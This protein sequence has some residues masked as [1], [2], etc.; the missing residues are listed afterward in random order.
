MSEHAP[1]VLKAAPVVERLRPELKAK[2][3][4]IRE[5]GV[6]PRLAIVTD[7]YRGPI[8]KYIDRKQL[9][10]REL[11][12]AV[13][14]SQARSSEALESY[15][16]QACGDPET[17]GV[18]LQLPIAG[19]DALSPT[20][21]RTREAAL[22]DSVPITR[23]VD[24]LA[25][26]SSFT[27]ATPLGVKALLDYYV[28]DFLGEEIAL[29]GNGILVN[30]PF[31][32]LAR[33]AGAKNISVIDKDTPLKDR[34]DMLHAA[35]IVIAATGNPESL[36][37]DDVGTRLPKIIVDAGT[38]ERSGKNIGDMSAELRAYAEST[39]G[40]GTTPPVGGVGPLTVWNLHSNVLSAAESAMS[41]GV[42]PQAW[43]S[44][45]MTGQEYANM[46]AFE[47]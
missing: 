29:Y 5:Q 47:N 25:R 24:G 20:K 34:R 14:V 38:A 30:Q 1:I 15:L 27:P 16:R 7:N 46:L 41:T 44:D 33:S 3:A 8:K 13:D 17:S 40:W 11:G 10:G 36:T 42:A 6:V 35:R 45:G 39:A 28:P 19:L 23:D 43:L 31:E 4:S 22:L 9:V 2:A 12:I 32:K 21:R 18:I 26:G 37:L